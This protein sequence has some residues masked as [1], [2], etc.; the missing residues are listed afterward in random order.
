MKYLLAIALGPVQD[1]I[2]AARST[3]DLS[4][5]SALLVD[6]A[7]AAAEAVALHGVLIF[8]ATDASGKV[9]DGA[10][11]ILAELRDGVLPGT[12]AAQAKAAANAV[13]ESAWQKAKEAARRDRYALNEALGDAQAARFLEFYA[14]WVPYADAASY[15]LARKQAD[16]LLAARKNTRDFGLPPEGVA[17]RTI[18][19]K[20]P[21]DPAWECVLTAMPERDAAGDDPGSLRLRGTEFLDAISLIKRAK[22]RDE[23]RKVPSTRDLVRW[24]V[25]KASVVGDWE[26][27]S[28]LPEDFGYF[29]I[30]QADGDSMGKLLDGMK[31][32][33]EHRDFSRKLSTFAAK[34]KEIVRGHD[35]YPVYA[36]GDDVLAFLPVRTAVKCARDLA[37]TF[38]DSIKGATLSAGV[39][40]VHYRQPLSLSR[41][42]AVEAEKAA[43]KTDGK[44]ALC[45]AL[46]TRGGQPLEVTRHWDEWKDFDTIKEAFENGTLTRGVAYEL[47]EL[48][49]EFKQVSLSDECVLD[50]LSR[51]AKRIWER[52]KEEAKGPR[53]PL[54]DGCADNPAVLDQFAG[55]LIAAR[56]LAHKEIE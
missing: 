3:S 39:A 43:K 35:G 51:E 30:L 45:L 17:P 44:N 50:L 25:K 24:N 47:R 12:V 8:P 19:A 4:A 5:G 49:R 15:P 36:G 48:A 33:D 10:N 55:L 32:P 52:K 6:I 16:A 23:N 38:E 22:G 14:A 1:F 2:A 56:F 18:K 42:A 9:T 28:E 7:R 21:L 41:K 20:S 54:P 37:K 27:E 26:K 53:P 31:T 11:K 29:A 46:H 13:L 40:I 34:A